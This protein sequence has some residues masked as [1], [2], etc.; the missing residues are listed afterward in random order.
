MVKPYHWYIIGAITF[1]GWTILVFLALEAAVFFTQGAERKAFGVLQD[2]SGKALVWMK[3]VR[4]FI[5]SSRTQS[6][7]RCAHRPSR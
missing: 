4:V 3:P 6:P 1:I 2:F 5:T 7:I